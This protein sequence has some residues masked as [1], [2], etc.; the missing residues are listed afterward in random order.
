[1]GAVE[2]L[3]IVKDVGALPDREGGEDGECAAVRL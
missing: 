2:E 3:E 1:M